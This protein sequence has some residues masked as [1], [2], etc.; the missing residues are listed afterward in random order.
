LIGEVMNQKFLVVKV[1]SIVKHFFV[2]SI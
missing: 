1:D 2:T